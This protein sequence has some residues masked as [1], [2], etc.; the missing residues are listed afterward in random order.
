MLATRSGRVWLLLAGL[1]ATV[2]A[3]PALRLLLSGQLGS[4]NMLEY[5]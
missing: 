5:I 4:N 2:D 3:T 1:L